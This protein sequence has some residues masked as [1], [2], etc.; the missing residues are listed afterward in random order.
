MQIIRPTLL[1]DKSKCLKN[2][3]MMTIKAQ[4]HGL[5]FRPHFKTHRS[6]E[7]AGWFRDFG[8]NKCTVSCVEMAK[9]FA[10]NG[11]NDITIAFTVN[12]LEI[13][14][15]NKIASEIKL[16]LL[17]ESLDAI[18][19][20]EKNL[21]N[22]VGVYLKIDT[23]YHRTGVNF[24]DLQLI[25]LLINQI[26]IA[27]NLKFI[28]FLTHSGNTYHAQGKAEILQ[29]HEHSCLQLKN[30]KSNLNLKDDC[31][32]SIGDTPSCS[33]SDNFEDIDEIRPGNF[34][35][36]D[37]MQFILG[38]CTIDQI[39]VCVACP[40]VAKNSERNE[41]V[42]YGGSVH[43]SKESFKLNDKA[44]F[45]LVVELN[46]NGWKL[47]DKAYVKSVSQEHGVLY[48][49]EEYFQ[50]INIGNVIGILPVHSCLTVGLMR[51]YQVLQTGEIINTHP[52]NN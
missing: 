30:L 21:K 37:T 29:I 10:E 43:L 49:P 20:L 4:K 42:I 1:L 34:I 32:I 19:F 25:K 35:F 14:N 26:N 28:G 45:G 27:E 12:I 51:K 44:I 18:N 7:I 33:L 9:Y 16:N 15:I 23:G 22:K 40:V 52:D 6:A 50:K 36:Y 31:L 24:N 2:I 48:M 3:E 39:A 41:V 17:V 11:W 38:S 5:E 13:E 8:I 46:D 47:I